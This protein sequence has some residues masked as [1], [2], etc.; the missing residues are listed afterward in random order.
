MLQSPPDLK[1]AKGSWTLH[2]RVDCCASHRNASFIDHEKK[3][4]ENQLR[5]MLN[6]SSPA[7]LVTMTTGYFLELSPPTYKASE[8]QALSEKETL[9]RKKGYREKEHC[10]KK[11]R[12]PM[13]KRPLTRNA[14]DKET[15][16]AEQ[17]ISSEEEPNFAEDIMS[18]VESAFVFPT[19]TTKRTG[20]T[21]MF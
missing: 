7:Y 13:R 17:D 16:S 4:I 2:S 15:N 21:K 6:K 19:T 3:D 1:M 5:R 14:S 10:L 9:P 8:K 11:R 18:W 20:E 12:Y